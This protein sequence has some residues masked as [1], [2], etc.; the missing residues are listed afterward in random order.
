MHRYSLVSGVPPSCIREADC[1]DTRTEGG[2]HSLLGPQ[3]LFH[4][5]RKP[6]WADASIY[7]HGDALTKDQKFNVLIS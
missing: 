7:S 2:K 6:D 1:L 5:N 4:G 3:D